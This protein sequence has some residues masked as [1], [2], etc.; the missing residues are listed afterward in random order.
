MKGRSFLLIILDRSSQ[1][2][3]KFCS[4]VVKGIY[5]QFKVWGRESGE[6]SNERC[7]FSSFE[8]KIGIYKWKFIG[9]NA[10]K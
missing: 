10:L 9:V 3:A 7:L 8:D 6:E 2:N 1:L 5:T 4:C